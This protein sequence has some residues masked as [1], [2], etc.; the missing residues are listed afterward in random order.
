MHAGALEAAIKKE[1]GNKDGPVTPETSAP[2]RGHHFVND[3]ARGLGEEADMEGDQAEEVQ[4]SAAAE[5]D[6]FVE[7]ADDQEGEQVC[8][9]K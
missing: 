2:G 8:L 7:E 5:E 4:E 3:E 6:N 9:S 1:L